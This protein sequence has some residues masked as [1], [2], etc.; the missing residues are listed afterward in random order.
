M[1]VCGL[2]LPSGGHSES[3]QAPVSGPRPCCHLGACWVPFISVLS[4]LLLSSSPQTSQ[5]LRSG[6]IQFRKHLF[7]RNCPDALKIQGR[8]RRGWQRMRWLDGITDSMDVSLFEL[9]ELVR[10]NRTPRACCGWGGW[11]TP[12][13]DRDPTSAQPRLHKVAVP[14]PCY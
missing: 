5:W 4:I 2:A 7:S 8:R 3:C 10:H 6:M 13:G 9:R 11:R 14:G 1:V 12:G